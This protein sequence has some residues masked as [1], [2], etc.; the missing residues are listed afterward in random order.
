MAKQ[1]HAFCKFVR[2]NVI[3]EIVEVV[4]FDSTG[5]TINLKGQ[6]LIVDYD[7]VSPITH[8]EE[9]ASAATLISG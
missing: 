8:K 2:L 7:E 9:A 6:N 3:G 5:M 1:F 4:G